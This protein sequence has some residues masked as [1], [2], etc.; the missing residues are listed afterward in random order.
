MKN[1]VNCPGREDNGHERPTEIRRR[2]ERDDSAGRVRDRSRSGVVMREGLDMSKP[3]SENGLSTCAVDEE[4][5]EE[6]TTT[7]RGKKMTFVQY[8]YRDFDGALFSTIKP[9]LEECREARHEWRH[10]KRFPFRATAEDTRPGVGNYRK[11]EERFATEAEARDWALLV[12]RRSYP[13]SAGWKFQDCGHQE[14]APRSVAFYIV[15][16]GATGEVDRV[17]VTIY[18]E[19]LVED[20]AE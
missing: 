1:A 10:A 11:E 7:V 14:S 13:T 3:M 8:D 16:D 2:P 6:F 15:R 9:T 12:L 4:K 17:T 19:T 18:D 20:N 5:Y